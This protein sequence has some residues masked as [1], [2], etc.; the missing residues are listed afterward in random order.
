[1][2]KQQ[3]TRPGYKQSVVGVI[4]DEWES[5]KVGAVCGWIV[6]G[7]NKPKRFDGDIP[8]ITTPDLEDGKTV[9]RSR[10]SLCISRDEAKAVGSKIVPPGSVLMSCAGELGIVALTKNEIVVNQQLHVFIPTGRIDGKFLLYALAHQKR[11]IASLATKTAV[12][13]LNKN[14]CNSI[15]I[16]LP[17]LPEQRI[18]AIT[19]SDVDGLIAWLDRLISKKRDLKQATMQQL[20]TGKRRLLGFAGEWEVKTLGKLGQISGAGVDKK[21]H[22]DEPPVRLVNYMDVYRHNFIYSKDLDHFVSARPEH[23]ARCAVKRGDVFFTPSS[24]MPF[25]IAVS[26]VAMEDIPDAAYS[27]HVVRLRLDEC[28]DLLFRAYA[29]KSQEFLNQAARACE[30]SGVRYVITQGKFRQLSVRFPPTKEE[31]AAI[32]SVLSDIDGELAALEQRRDKAR[33][34]KQGMMQELLT[35]NTRLI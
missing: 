14:N 19:L 1:M 23:A 33:A 15:P 28:W 24:E 25:D 2:A 30:G 20:L 16:P 22:P 29:F 9:T 18:I 27:Y 11:H 35:G 26:A 8:W 6:P 34:L 21:I 3:T 4:P 7:R 32:G 13:Y 10:I 31:Q 12:P 5:P 17:P